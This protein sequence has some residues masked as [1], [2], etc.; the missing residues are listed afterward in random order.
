M[1]QST[2]GIVL[3]GFKYSDTSLIVK[4]LTRHLDLQSYLVPGIRKSK[5][6]IKANIFQPFHLVEMVVYH[7]ERS[8]LQRIKE[9]RLSQNLPGLSSDIRKTSLA[10]FLSEILLNAFKHQEP[11]PEAFEFIASSI[12]QL[13]TANSNISLFHIHFLIQLSRFLGFAPGENYSDKCQ[14]FNLREG[15]FQIT[16]DIGGYSLEKDISYYLYQISL[17][18]PENNKL[19]DIP[20]SVKKAILPRLIDYYRLHLEGF[21]EIKSFQVLDAV[22]H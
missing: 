17:N 4:I 13:D 21:R 8:G 19:T 1:L 14:Y 5:S 15:I 16:P 22:F 9:I 6:R 7:K 2:Q 20:K 18:K 3:H 10:I 11:Q 12:I